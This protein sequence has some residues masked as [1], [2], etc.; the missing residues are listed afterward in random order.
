MKTKVT[1]EGTRVIAK[2]RDGADHIKY[3]FFSNGT[4]AAKTLF[5]GAYQGSEPAR[6]K[7]TKT[8]TSSMAKPA[9]TN[10]PSIK[11]SNAP[12]ITKQ[13]QTELNRLGCSV[14]IADGAVGPA[15]KRGLA[16]F[17]DVTGEAGYNVS[18][19]SNKKFLSFLKGL[20]SRFCN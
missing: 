6:G 13:V 20:P 1:Y 10:K 17:A 7:C 8:V 16:K 4:M 19:F 18:E 11:K 2:Y 15:S 12:S 14:G 5:A 3:V 9:G